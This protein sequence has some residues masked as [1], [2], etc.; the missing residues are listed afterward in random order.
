LPAAWNTATYPGVIGVSSNWRV[1][2]MPAGW[3]KKRAR[4]RHVG[5]NRAG[6]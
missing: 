1:S 2:G 3:E 5:L 6:P 4:G